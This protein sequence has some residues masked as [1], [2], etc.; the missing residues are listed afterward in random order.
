MNEQ[1]SKGKFEHFMLKEIYEQP[2]I[3]EEILKNRVNESEFNLD[4]ANFTKEELENFDTIYITACGTA[5]HAGLV[6]KFLIQKYLGIR[7]V[8]EIAS[9]FMNIDPIVNEKT[10]V[11]VISQSGETSDTLGALE[12]AKKKGATVLAITNV[13]D[14]TIARKADKVL[15]CNAGVEVAIASTKAYIAQVLDMY[16]L[17]I[18]WGIKLGKIDSVT[19]NK[20]L[21]DLNHVSD[22]IREVLSDHLMYKEAAEELKKCESVFYLG[23][24]IDYVSSREASLKLKETSYIHSEAYP[25]GELKHGT[26][27]LV[28]DGTVAVAIVT[29]SKI[30]TQTAK[31]MR[32]LKDRGAKLITISS[33][34]CEEVDANS[35]ILIKIDELPETVAPLVSIVPAQL[36]AYYTS[37]A[38][39]NDVDQ[40]RNLTKAVI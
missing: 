16:L 31:I 29:D 12:V 9:E 8:D 27:A 34:D 24:N 1:V 37:L 38:K 11:I 20:L 21:R 2:E 18:D 19:S 40:P 7:V 5:L 10:L 30:A 3:V 36:M 22:K 33:V 4:N 6:G 13:E 32:E 35:D 17:T 14:S 23:R 28:E 25:A 39:G 26:F 15:Y